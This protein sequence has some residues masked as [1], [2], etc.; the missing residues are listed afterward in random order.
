VLEISWT[1]LYLIIMKIKKKIIKAL[2]LGGLVPPMLA[3][4]HHTAWGANCRREIYDVEI[5]R[6][7]MWEFVS[8]HDTLAEA[9]KSFGKQLDKAIKTC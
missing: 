5:L 1:I 3:I 6:G 8:T 7:A 2:C 4:R 9:N